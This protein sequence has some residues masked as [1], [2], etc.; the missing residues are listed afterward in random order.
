MGRATGRDSG[1][2]TKILIR[3]PE[4]GMQPGLIRTQIRGILKSL[5]SASHATKADAES[6][7]INKVNL[8]CYGAGG[9][10][11]GAND[12]PK[13]G[14][15]KIWDT[16]G[17]LYIG[18][19]RDK[20]AENKRSNKGSIGLFNGQLSYCSDHVHETL[21]ITPTFYSVEEARTTLEK[22]FT[23]SANN[24]E[25]DLLK[26][27]IQQIYIKAGEPKIKDRL[28]ISITSNKFIGNDIKKSAL[29]YGLKGDVNMED[30][31]LFKL[32]HSLKS[33]QE[34]FTSV[35][36][37]ENA[38]PF[39]DKNMVIRIDADPATVTPIE[40]DFDA[41]NPETI[42]VDDCA[43]IVKWGLEGLIIKKIPPAINWEGIVKHIRDT[44]GDENIK[45]YL[46]PVK[47]TEIYINPFLLETAQDLFRETGEWLNHLPDP[48]T[49]PDLFSKELQKN[50]F[51]KNI[52]NREELK[53]LLDA[54]KTLDKELKDYCKDKSKTIKLE[55]TIEFIK[56]LYTLV[57]LISDNRVQ[58]W[59]RGGWG[60]NSSEP[61]ITEN[62]NFSGSNIDRALYK[63]NNLT[64]LDKNAGKA[65]DTYFK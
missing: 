15:G 12:S 62:V 50:P 49:K 39:I 37:I 11:C 9:A 46:I 22:T 18:V 25:G 6:Q 51:N 10:Y 55:T 48:K 32:I 61:F 21:Y 42:T 40:N 43:E 28:G 59:A 19:E 27:Q 65:V 17:S 41:A 52:P 13:G 16:V 24:D 5:K 57:D 26:A 45:N 1:L 7:E 58:I 30:Y 20:A 2:P 31:H 44:V 53:P 23:T 56:S 8:W 33:A 4:M 54:H 29:N 64:V 14:P 63:S 3:S 47:G 34:N 38:Y 35:K 36:N 60:G